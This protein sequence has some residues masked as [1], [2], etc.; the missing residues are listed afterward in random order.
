M[1]ISVELAAFHPPTLSKPSECAS[2][3]D[4]TRAD[5]IKF[6]MLGFVIHSKI[7]Q[8]RTYVIK[9]LLTVVFLTN[10]LVLNLKS[11]EY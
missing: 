10:V 3:R 2:S 4:K 7:K 1:T 11:R 9:H 8:L 6:L 5:I